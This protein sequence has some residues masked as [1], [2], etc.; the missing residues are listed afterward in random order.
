MVDFYLVPRGTVYVIKCQI[1]KFPFVSLF[2]LCVNIFWEGGGVM[3]EHII[4]PTPPSK[5]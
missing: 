2:F 4:N 5:N 3:N 1:T